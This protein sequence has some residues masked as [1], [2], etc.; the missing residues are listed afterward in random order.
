MA[1]EAPQRPVSSVGLDGR[2]VVVSA[3][4][5]GIELAIWLQAE[6][7][8][9]EQAAPGLAAVAAAPAERPGGDDDDAEPELQVQAD[10][11]PEPG[12]L[13]GIIGAVI[14]FLFG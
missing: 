2:S 5:R 6:W 11:P 3:T 10:V 4:P 7:L 13:E 8:L 1:V 14:G 12:L 9:F